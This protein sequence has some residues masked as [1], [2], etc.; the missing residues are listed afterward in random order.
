M[1]LFFKFKN[2]LYDAIKVY[3][4]FTFNESEEIYR[5]LTVQ[6]ENDIT[7]I[8]YKERSLIV[9]AISVVRKNG[10]GDTSLDLAP[11]NI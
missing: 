8:S 7:N 4:R 2:E 6:K 5:Y 10:E 1:K 11:I 3:G 9:Q